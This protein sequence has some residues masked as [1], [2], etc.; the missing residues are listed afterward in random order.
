MA[1]A[2][3]PP[4]KELTWQTYKVPIILGGVSLLLIVLSIYLLIKTYQASEPIQFSR[5][6]EATATG[7]GTQAAL[8]IDVSG[9]VI[10]PNVYRLPYGSRVDDAILAAGG[11]T[12]EADT[13]WIETSMNRAAKVSDGAKVFIPRK[14]DRLNV[15]GVSTVQSSTD[16]R[17]ESGTHLVSI[18]S[19]SSADLERLNGIGPVTAGKIIAGRPY[20]RLEELVEKK[21]VSQT[22]FDTL[23]NQLTL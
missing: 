18:N 14:K 17:V 9:A 8:L 5:A 12:R 1:G 10:H 11:M 2:S 19:A 6:S 13:D 4:P 22:L 23:K 3:Q 20:S 21:A 7:S 15:Q 16:Q